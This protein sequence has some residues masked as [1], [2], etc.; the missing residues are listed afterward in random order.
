ML[1]F[2]RIDNILQTLETKHYYKEL[3]FRKG[4]EIHNT[5]HLC[6]IIICWKRDD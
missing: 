4:N 1:D 5:L 3:N 6:I 2:I